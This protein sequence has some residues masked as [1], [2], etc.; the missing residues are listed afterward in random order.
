MQHIVGAGLGVLFGGGIGEGFLTAMFSSSIYG[1]DLITWGFR[2]G[3]GVGLLLGAFA[4][5][6]ACKPV[7]LR[8]VC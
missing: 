5:H 4:A 6:I 3:A 2:I 8:Q 7:P 1:S